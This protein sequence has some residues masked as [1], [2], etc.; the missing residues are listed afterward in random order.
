MSSESLSTLSART[1]RETARIVDATFIDLHPDFQREYEAWSEKLCTGFIETILIG[2]ATNPIWLVINETN[3]CV[4]VLD[5]MHRL[6]TAI[7]F[8]HNQ[9]PIG[10]SVS[11]IDPTKYKDKYFRDLSKDDQQRYRTYR[12]YLNV[13]DASYRD[14]DKLNEMYEILNCS[15]R[16]LNEYEQKKPLYKPLYD[17]IAPYSMRI[18][19]SPLYPKTESKRGDNDM[20]FLSLIALAQPN[21]PTFSSLRDNYKKWAA[22]AF[23]EKHDEITKNLEEKKEAL[24][25]L[26]KRIIRYLDTFRNDERLFD[27]EDEVV[28]AKIIVARCAA[29]IPSV[30]LF[31]RHSTA[32][33]AALKVQI[34]DRIRDD[35]LGLVG[36]NAVFQKTVIATVDA[37]IHAEIG[38]VAAP[39]LFSR[40]QIERRLT[41]QNKQ[42]AICNK[43]IKTGQKYEG[44]HILGWAAGGQT[45]YENLQVV[46]KH[47]CHRVGKAAGGE[48]AAP[49][50]EKLNTAASTGS[51]HQLV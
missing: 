29:L 25:E 44:D 17:L 30:A 22:V 27:G 45:V 31:N 36:R 39:R 2:R 35:N 41:E 40:E 26:S 37:V 13:L 18:F 51:V 1:N 10:K 6:T 12:F 46:H 42:C 49:A 5:G 32:L 38:T 34:F 16:P 15:A 14:E 28:A 21:L 11:A 8:L 24:T 19:D 3:D 20:A 48:V 33:S 50:P 7:R 47:K 4:D 43:E 9:F 23:G